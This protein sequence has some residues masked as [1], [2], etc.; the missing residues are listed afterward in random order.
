MGD[1]KVT[2]IITAGDVKYDSTQ[3]RTTQYCAIERHLPRTE[4]AVK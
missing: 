4:E 1:N 3:P 2:Y